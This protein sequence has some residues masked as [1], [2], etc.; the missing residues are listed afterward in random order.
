M[1]AVIPVARVKG[2]KLYR[3]KANGDDTPETRHICPRIT[4]INVD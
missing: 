3:C 1:K 4:Q 2:L